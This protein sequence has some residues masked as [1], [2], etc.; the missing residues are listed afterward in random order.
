MLGIDLL[1]WLESQSC[2]DPKTEME[3]GEILKE[4]GLILKEKNETRKGKVH[5]ELI[6]CC[7]SVTSATLFFKSS[8]HSL[9]H[10]DFWLLKSYH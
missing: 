3:M 2:L 7:S 10:L 5:F 4:M 9:H 8:I 1:W 6:I